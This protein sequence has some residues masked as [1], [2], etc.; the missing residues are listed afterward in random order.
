MNIENKSSPL[1]E[2]FSANQVQETL[3][4][5]NYEQALIMAKSVLTEHP[6]D[7]Y[8]LSVVANDD[9]SK[10]NLDSA[11]NH[12]LNA[13]EIEPNELNLNRNLGLLYNRQGEFKASVEVFIRAIEHNFEHQEILLDVLLMGISLDKIL[14]ELSV[15]LIN[16]V[17]KS[18]PALHTAYMNNEELPLIVEA[19]QIAN[20]IV[21]DY[22]YVH[23]KKALE[24]ISLGFEEKE[25]QRL[26]EFLDVFH[27][28]KQPVSKH[29]MQNPTYH[30]FP[31]LEAKP[32]YQTNQFDW[33][34][35]LENS[36]QEIKQELVSI[37][38]RDSDVKPYI[39]GVLT[40]V[41]GL[42][43]LADSLD[44]S[45]VHLI[46]AGQ[47]NQDLLDKCPITRDIIQKIPLPLLDGNAPEAFLS[48]LKPGAEIK[49]H[50]GLSNIKLTVHLGLE[51]PDG[52]AIR[53]GDETQTWENGKVLI[54]DDTF[55]HEAWN[56]SNSERMVFIL[57]I[58]HPDLT[59]L[60]KQGIQKVMEL[61]HNMSVLSESDSIESILTEIKSA[62]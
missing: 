60:E 16:L 9:F 32:F 26:Y 61:Q 23:Q 13:L 14:P 5:G 44:W 56:R 51:I 40:G 57:E 55:E 20:G 29:K 12:L 24:V 34:A 53:V 35:N 1:Q 49:P 43:S 62:I 28:F 50:Y 11:K 39:D 45:S 7:V 33:V 4:S 17:F 6:T 19:S 54:F 59:V 25:K 3:M 38:K 10:G 2:R 27:G 36:W 37:Y 21:R 31:D 42:D 41:E 52:C 15:R 18:S 8:C 58:W 47:Y 22:K 48:V 46:K 30:V